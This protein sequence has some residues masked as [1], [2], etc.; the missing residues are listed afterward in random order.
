M[1][2]KVS[3]NWSLWSNFCHAFISVSDAKV[4]VASHMIGRSFHVTCHVW[5]NAFPQPCGERQL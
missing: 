3:F 1:F 5:N 4:D 2:Q